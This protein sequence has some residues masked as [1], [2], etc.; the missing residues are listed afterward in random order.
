MHVSLTTAA[1]VLT[2]VALTLALLYKLTAPMRKSVIAS[3]IPIP[4]LSTTTDRKIGKQAVRLITHA[5]AAPHP[6]KADTRGEDAL[7]MTDGCVGV[8]DGVGAFRLNGNGDSG[9]Y[10]REISVR[11]KDGL[12]RFPSAV[13]ALENAVASTDAVGATTAC[14][15]DVRSGRAVGVSIGD[16]KAIILRDGGIVLE[17]EARQHS[18][19]RPVQVGKWSSDRVLDGE[20]F[21]TAVQQGDC[22]VMASDGLWDNVYMNRVSQIVQF[23]IGRTGVWRL[24]GGPEG[25]PLERDVAGLA[26]SIARDLMIEAMIGADNCTWISPFADSADKNGRLHIGGKQDDITIVVAFVLA[27][28]QSADQNGDD[29]DG[30]LLP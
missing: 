17:T 29:V 3:K 14:V 16:S 27:T 10:A 21:D 8:F 1:M 28:G 23:Q 25:L 7:F 26:G 5:E 9:V 11:T 22:V 4:N 19:N 30:S 6:D 12:C 15:L 20:F 18:F 24:E 13:H 2:S